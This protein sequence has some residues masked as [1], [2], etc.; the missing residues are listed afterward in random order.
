[1][2]RAT[3]DQQGGLRV[4]HE[5]GLVSGPDGLSGVPRKGS[6]DVHPHHYALP[7][8]RLAR[9]RGH[10]EIADM[11][12]AGP[13]PFRASMQSSDFPCVMGEVLWWSF[14]VDRDS[15]VTLTSFYCST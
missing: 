1:M 13:V 15:S 5:E 12:N 10:R 2:R 4:Q 9:R 7:A 14:D 11:K 3:T 6:L 8:V